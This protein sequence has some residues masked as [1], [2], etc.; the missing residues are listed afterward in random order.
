M[1]QSSILVAGIGN[2]FLGDDAFG[3][4]VVKQLC[5]RPLPADVCVADFGIRSYDLAYAILDGYHATILIDATARGQP[6]GTLL[7]IEP[8]L[9]ELD[10]LASPLVDSH[11]MNPVA[12]L[13]LVKIFGGRPQRLYLVGC[14]PETFVLEEGL[15][16]L[17]RTV[18]HAIPQAIEMIE[19]LLLKLMV[20][21][22]VESETGYTL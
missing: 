7:L 14:E 4:E 11:S 3:V 20:G 22:A 18:Q 19:T 13:Q 1:K 8:N 21:K 2:I 5:R 12:A 6:P 15:I 10:Q 17:S 16:G 9:D